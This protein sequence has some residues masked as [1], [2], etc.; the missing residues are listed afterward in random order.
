MGAH[1][2]AENTDDL[3]SIM[4]RSASRRSRAGMEW[5]YWAMAGVN[6]A[7]AAVATVVGVWLLF[8]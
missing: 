3:I 4:A 5:P 8:F 6:L 2:R 7:A 1:A